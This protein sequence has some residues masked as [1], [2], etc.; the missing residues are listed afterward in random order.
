[1]FDDRKKDNKNKIYNKN[2]FL[3]KLKSYKNNNLKDLKKY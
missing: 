2:N 3:K 1:M